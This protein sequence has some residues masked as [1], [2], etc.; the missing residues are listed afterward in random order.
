MTI[1]ASGNLYVGSWEVNP[2]IRKITPDGTVTTLAGSPGAG[3][4]T[5]GVGSAA[6]FRMPWT[7]AI[8]AQGVLWVVDI[9]SDAFH[10]KLRKVLPDG[11]VT[12]VKTDWPSGQAGTP[13]VDPSGV[14]YF[15]S[16]PD[17]TITKMTPD[18]TVTLLA[19]R[20]GEQGAADGAG[21]VARFNSPTGIVGDGAGTLYVS[22]AYKERS[23]RS[24]APDVNRQAT[25]G[26]ASREE[27]T[28]NDRPREPGGSRS[29]HR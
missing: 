8:D 24:G 23:A 25:P 27:R 29:W 2:A 19:G 10:S 15:T 7:L 14:L 5:D 18:G 12:T 16:Y 17:S 6:R 13:W 9:A 20:P 3:G 21:D 26:L 11:T 28:I 22:D 1:D 4:A